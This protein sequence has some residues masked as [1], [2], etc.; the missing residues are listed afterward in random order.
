MEMERSVIQYSSRN[1]RQNQPR[2]KQKQKQS[3]RNDTNET[4][5]ELTN[6]LD[7]L[8]LVSFPPNL[9]VVVPSLSGPHPRLH[10]TTINQ[11]FFFSLN[12]RDSLSCTPLTSKPN[13]GRPFST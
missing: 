7:K 3:T 11:I 13:S 2:K 8:Y 9:R 5:N 12:R 10:K 6:Y 1:L 4:N